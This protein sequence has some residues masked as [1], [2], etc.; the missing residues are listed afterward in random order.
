MIFEAAHGIGALYMKRHA[1]SIIVQ[2]FPRVARLPDI[3]RLKQELLLDIIDAVAEY[4]SPASTNEI[5]S[6]VS[7][8][9]TER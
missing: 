4:M 7:T 5:I 1:L 9:S 2:Q 3:R 8:Y 6:V